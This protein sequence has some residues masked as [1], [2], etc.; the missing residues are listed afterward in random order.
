[1]KRLL[2][3]FSMMGALLNAHAGLIYST[4]FT[5]AE[6]PAWSENGKI[7]DSSDWSGSSYIVTTNITGSGIA[8]NS[9]KSNRQASLAQGYSMAVG[10]TWTITSSIAADNQLNKFHETFS[11]GISGTAGTTVG[12]GASFFANNNWTI[13]VQYLD[14]ADSEGAYVTDVAGVVDAFV[15]SVMTI[16]KSA[17]ANEFIITAA[18]NGDTGA[19]LTHTVVDAELYADTEIFLT[20]D[21]DETDKSLGMMDSMS[22]STSIPEPATFGMLGLGAIGLL[23]M[24]RRITG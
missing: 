12:A 22:L 4:D 15:T 2:I 5:S 19:G 21:F 17:T 6:D 9:N 18:I 8:K 23:F 1:M 11:I 3:A 14:N 24:R 7:S 10:E 16:T 13:G 20:Y